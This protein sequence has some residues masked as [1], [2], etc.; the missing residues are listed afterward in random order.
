MDSIPCECLKGDDD[1]DPLEES[2]F[3]NKIGEAI[4]AFGGAGF[5]RRW[6]ASN[7]GGDVGIE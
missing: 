5:V 1:L 4:I 7:N 6:G 2:D 3:G